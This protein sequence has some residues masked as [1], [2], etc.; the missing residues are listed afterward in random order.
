MHDS[1]R[2]PPR[3]L[4]VVVAGELN[5]DI[6]IAG[7]PKRPA[8]GQVEATIDGITLT[9]GSSSAIFACGAARL[10]LRV[11]FVGIVG[12]DP[13]GRFMLDALADRGIDVAACQTDPTRPTGASAILV[14]GVD[15]AILT[16]MGTIDL[17]RAD[18]FPHELLLRARHLHVGSL[19]LQSG[20]RPG[21]PG[22][23][24]RA[25]S[26][27]LSVSLDCNWDPSGRWDSLDDLLARADIFLPNATEACR[28][29]GLDEDLGAARELARRAGGHLAVA[30]K[31]GAAGATA[32]RGDIVEFA[33]ASPVRVV[34]TVGAG[35]SFDAGF[36][37]GFL[38]D[39][40]LE[41]TLRLAVA[42]GSLSTLRAGGTDAQPTFVEAAA[43]IASAGLPPPAATQR[44]NDLPRPGHGE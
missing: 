27:G 16:A 18:D 15:R 30:V 4:D 40:P 36:V 19:Y 12:D 29:A 34:D 44:R 26:A 23:L 13:F 37:Y 10:G 38:A 42:C 28:L 31:R 1:A 41:A 14:R 32:V 2:R 20:L 21:L 17:M 24:E 25:R 6:I 39:W 35:D 43:A 22:L 8:F 9:I 11:A 33:P 5:P 3:D 7:A